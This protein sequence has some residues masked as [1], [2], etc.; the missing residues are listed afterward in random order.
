[1]QPLNITT[2]ATLEIDGKEYAA[3]ISATVYPAREQTRD[4][5]GDDQEIEI[6]NIS[7]KDAPVIWNLF[8]PKLTALHEDACVAAVQNKLESLLEK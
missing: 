3:E 2:A 1:M 7:I 6:E 5:P 8:P 4:Y